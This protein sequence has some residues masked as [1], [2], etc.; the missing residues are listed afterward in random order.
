MPLIEDTQKLLQLIGP[1]KMSWVTWQR[2]FR[3]YPGFGK[4]Y[5]LFLSDSEEERT[6]LAQSCRSRHFCADRVGVFS[7]TENLLEPKLDYLLFVRNLDPA[8]TIRI[9]ER[10]QKTKIL[11]GDQGR[12]IGIDL[13]EN[14]ETVLSDVGL[15]ATSPGSGRRLEEAWGK[16]RGESVLCFKYCPTGFFDGLCWLGALNELAA[17]DGGEKDE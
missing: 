17:P 5:A 9:A 3:D 13:P 8:S 10:F 4:G 16:W 14:R 6:R 15:D 1:E 11:W 7:A 2:L 12:I